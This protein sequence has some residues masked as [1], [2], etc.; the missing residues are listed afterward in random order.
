MSDLNLQQ[1]PQENISHQDTPLLDT[2]QEGVH[3]VAEEVVERPTPKITKPKTPKK[4]KRVKPNVS[5]KFLGD[6]DLRSLRALNK[7]MAKRLGI[8]SNTSRIV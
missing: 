8:K 6:E 2:E 7:E 3:L 5:G 1:N 4:P